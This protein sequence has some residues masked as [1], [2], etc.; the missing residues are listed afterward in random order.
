MP[1]TENQAAAPASTIAARVCGHADGGEGRDSR[2]HH[3]GG[4]RRNADRNG[5]CIGKPTISGFSAQERA[6]GV[7][8]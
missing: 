6:G 5:R 3:C 1:L 8:V 2:R 7:G 4:R